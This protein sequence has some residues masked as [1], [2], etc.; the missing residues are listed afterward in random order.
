MQPLKLCLN[1][2]SFK[3]LSPK[4]NQVKS[5]RPW[6]LNMLKID[7]RT[8]WI[9]ANNLLW[10]TSNDLELIIFGSE[11]YQ[12]SIVYEKNEFLK[13][14]VLQLKKSFILISVSYLGV[15]IFIILYIQ[16]NPL[17]LNH[18]QD[19]S[20]SGL[21]LSKHFSWKVSWIAPVIAGAAL[22][23]TDLFFEKKRH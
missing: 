13:L 16:Q 19:L 5:F 6:R 17:S 15:P 12:D 3:W 22:Y 2:C 10:K 21:N 23:W 7:L 20:I 9:K 14:S 11:L 4:R 1:L 18:L 8:S